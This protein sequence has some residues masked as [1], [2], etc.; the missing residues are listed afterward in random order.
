MVAADFNGDGWIDVA[1]ISVQKPD[2]SDTGSSWWPTAAR[3]F[4]NTKNCH[5][6]SQT[7]NIMPCGIGSTCTGQPSNGA[8]TGTGL[9]SGTAYAETNLSC[10]RNGSS[11]KCPYYFPRS[12]RTI[13]RDGSA[14]TGDGSTS[15]AD[16]YYPGDFGPVG[17]SAGSIVALDWD[18]DGDIDI[19]FGHSGGTCPSGFCSTSGHEFWPGIEV[20]KNDCANGSWWN[21]ATK[22]CPTHIPTFSHTLGSCTGSSACTDPETLIP[23]TAHNTTTLAPTDELGFDASTTKSY[24]P[25]FAYEDIDGDGKRDLVIGSPGCCSVARTRPIGSGSTRARVRARTS[26]ARPRRAR[27]S[28]TSIPQNPTARDKGGLRAYGVRGTHRRVRV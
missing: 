20:W 10:T 22:S 25:A 11:P 9:T 5:K 13:F 18:G 12:R 14:V 24:V 23:S 15:S 17:W 7:T 19:L 21:A 16:T 27:S 1:A 4:L 8:C 6:A 2:S 28:T 3:L 26:R